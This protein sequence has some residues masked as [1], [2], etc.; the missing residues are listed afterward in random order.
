MMLLATS[1][2]ASAVVGYIGYQ[3]G[4]SSLRAAAF[5]GL[6]EIRASQARE[7]ETLFSDLM[8]SLV[9]YSRGDSATAAVTAFTDAF[10]ELN[11]ATVEPAQY[12]AIVDYYESHFG[13]D[14]AG[15]AGGRLRVEAL[16]PSS[17]AQRYLQAHYT[18]PFDDWDEAINNDDAG[19]GSAWSAA[20]AR[21]NDF[22]REIVTRFEFED[23]LLLDTRGNVVYSAYKGVDL[24]TNLHTGPYRE[25][26]LSEAY[27]RALA[28]NV[29][30]YVGLTDFSAY[31]PTSEPTAWMVSPIGPQ[32]RVMG[33]LALQFPID[34]INRL[35]TA[36]REWE[37]VG[38]GRTGETYL[39]GTDDLMRS[40]SRLFLEDPEQFKTDVVEAGT[41]PAVAEESLRRGG[42]TLV[43][44]VLGAAVDRA[45]R[46]QTG[47]LIGQDY[48]GRE[49]LQAY[50]PVDLPGLH[51]SIVAEKDTVE[52]FAP[53]AD[54]TRT[55][56]LSTVAII[57][58]VC[59]AA[60]LLA[61]FFVRPIRQLQ[62]GAQRISVGDYDVQLP[63]KSHDEFADLTVA[64][65]DMSRNLSIKE[66]LLAEQRR[67]NDRLLRSL[68]PE[69]VVQ[70][71]RDGEETIAQD[72][73]DVTVIFAD[74]VGLDAVSF[75]LP[76]AEAVPMVNEL[77]RQFDAA[78]DHHG[79]ERVR[80]MHNGYIASCGLS[81][82]RL[83][84][85]RRTVDFAL[86]MQRIVDRFNAES[87]HRLEL[88]AGIDTGT[89]KSGLVDRARLAYDMW[90]SAV[91][92]AYQV[93]TG[94]PQPGIFVTTRVHE[95]MRD[96]HP[97]Q[98]VGQVD[99]DGVAEPI[100]RLTE[101]Q[102]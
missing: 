31:Q 12:R 15:T 16:L 41:P 84:N 59:L 30:D 29:V 55:L 3:S 37:S 100:W 67:E 54:F 53:V 28:S 75:Q 34:K 14:T 48:L 70:R 98:Q 20:N 4:R 2:V 5:E 73:Q 36:D 49:T 32:G 1:I 65:N 13:S 42:T 57:F 92:I 63:V 46:G 9:I 19:D 90:G 26:E 82:P 44:P 91:N 99:N 39:V 61:R 81:M 7:L 79:V 6:T 52:A 96:S 87:G 45:Q 24:G 88:R 85:V 60:M 77:V 89:V 80:T 101:Q 10:N 56:V 47:T 94:S 64:F 33:V 51:W 38:M 50:A 69:P 66:E 62:T 17:N 76:S 78:A 102:P 97:F 40:D 74:I 22:F 58:A 8:N 23:A 25:S 35:M 27:R 71:Y 43:Q 72:H 83:D 18:A 93:Q 68:M 95:V 86:D 21:F 11:D